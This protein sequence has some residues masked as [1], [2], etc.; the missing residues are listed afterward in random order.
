LL[1]FEPE[2]RGHTPVALERLALVVHCQE[3]CGLLNRQLDHCLGEVLQ[4]DRLRAVRR[5]PV[6]LQ[7]EPA[8]L[9]ALHARHA[10]ELLVEDQQLHTPLVERRQHVLDA[11]G[12]ALPKTLQ[13]ILL[14]LP[15]ELLDQRPR[16]LQ[17]LVRARV[18]H[19]HLHPAG[20]QLAQVV[21]E[22][23][24]E[25]GHD[26]T[27][28]ADDEPLER[29]PLEV[30]QQ[31]VAGGLQV[32]VLLLLH[33]ALVA[34]LRPAALVVLAVHVVVDPLDL[35][36]AVGAAA[37]DAGVAPV[38]ERDAP[39]LAPRDA[40]QRPDQGRVADRDPVRHGA[41][42]LQGLEQVVPVAGEDCQG[43][44]AVGLK[45][46]LEE[47]P[48]PLEGG[49]EGGFVVMGEP[50]PLADAPLGLVQQRADRALARGRGRELRR[51]EIQIE[52]EHHR[53]VEPKLGEGAELVAV[54]RAYLHASGS[55]RRL[56]GGRLRR[57]LGK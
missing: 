27:R 10:A 57:I 9:E 4:L 24:L 18:L 26:L 54:R 52:A 37:E 15:F 6:A 19:V 56:P 41:R 32:V 51:I 50:V 53:P 46:V 7:A 42:Q 30:A 16:G 49:L 34:R 25:V 2:E 1:R 23:L 40:R 33:A 28:T 8:A 36:K 47:R 44:G 22:L 5:A 14:A 48:R 39:A 43:V 29:L 31:C 3:I 13:R 12:A 38:H 11:A 17:H 45:V 55:T 35:A 20:E 21:V